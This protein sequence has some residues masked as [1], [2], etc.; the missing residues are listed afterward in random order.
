[1]RIFLP[2]KEVFIEHWVIICESFSEPG[3]SGG[4]DLLERGLSHKTSVVKLVD[5]WLHR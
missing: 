3:Q 4:R 1:M 2:I 5:K